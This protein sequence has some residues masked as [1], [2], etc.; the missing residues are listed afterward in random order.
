MRTHVW[1]IAKIE[2]NQGKESE[3]TNLSIWTTEW[4]FATLIPVINLKR[5]VGLLFRDQGIT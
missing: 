3:H 2:S 4:Q 1:R 5:Y